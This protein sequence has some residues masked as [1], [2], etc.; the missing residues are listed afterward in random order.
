MRRR[1][2][3][4]TL[5]I[6]TRWRVLT[7][8]YTEREIRKSRQSVEAKGTTGFGVNRRLLEVSG[9]LFSPFL[10]ELCALSRL[11]RVSANIPAHPAI[12]GSADL[13]TV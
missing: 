9:F 8:R 11:N 6:Y 12:N 13:C 2:R 10:S 1:A 7:E 3:D 4:C 5:A